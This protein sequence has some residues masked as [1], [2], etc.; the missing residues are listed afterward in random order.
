MAKKNLFSYHHQKLIEHGQRR[1]AWKR[2]RTNSHNV[3]FPTRNH[4]LK[5]MTFNVESRAL[6]RPPSVSATSHLMGC[7]VLSCQVIISKFWQ[8]NN[9]RGL[10]KFSNGLINAW[11]GTAGADMAVWALFLLVMAFHIDLQVIYQSVSCARLI[12][13]SLGKGAV[14]AMHWK[15]I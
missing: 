4:P 8:W 5:G 7:L 12:G 2:K 15:T 9:A 3:R 11:W 13:P 10:W 1:K 6:I 14:K